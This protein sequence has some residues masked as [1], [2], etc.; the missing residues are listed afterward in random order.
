VRAPG[1]S[2][3]FGVEAAPAIPMIDAHLPTYDVNEVHSISS[4]ATPAALMLAA[5]G[6][7]PR[8]VPVMLAL[9][10]VRGLPALMT[11]RRLPAGGPIVDAFR[12]SGFVVLQ[13]TPDE[14]VLGG[15]GRFWQPLGGL[16]R[17]APSE[18]RDFAEPGWAK[19]AFAFRVERRAG[20]TVLTTETRVLGTDDRAR[21]SFGRYWRVIR[22]GSAAIR[23]D[24]LRAIR[25]RAEQT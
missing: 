16:R 1:R 12:K 8:E 18:F 13:E 23:V 17:I 7:T 20:R 21:R 14:I 3:S 9:M 22:P 11:G 4:S 10:A 2:G 6:V 24:W 19:A 25:R 15:V 5:R